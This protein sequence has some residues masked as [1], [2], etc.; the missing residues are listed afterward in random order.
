MCKVILLFVN[1]CECKEKTK[2]E[3]KEYIYKC[4]CKKIVWM[5]ESW[6]WVGYFFP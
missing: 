4:E 6:K 1:E 5:Q 2:C 3:C